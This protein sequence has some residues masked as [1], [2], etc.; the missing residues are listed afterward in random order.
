MGCI[1][2]FNNG[3]LSGTLTPNTIYYFDSAVNGGG[4]PSVTGSVTGSQVTLFFA[5]NIPFDFSN[6]GSVTLTPPGYGSSCIGS[7][8]PLCGILID[9]PTDGSANGG[10]YTCSHGKGNNEGN[11]GEIYLDFGSSKTVIDG[12]VYAPYMQLFG[13][14]KGSSTT[15]ASNLVI[16]NMCMQSSTFDVDG[17]SGAQSPLTRAGLVY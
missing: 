14:D 2:D 17:Y 10:T 9:A 8:N 7:V 12:I 13:Q 1:Y 3:D 15:F 5:G 16:G 11:P 6:N 4:G